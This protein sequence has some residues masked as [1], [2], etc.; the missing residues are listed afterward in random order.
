L[1]FGDLTVKIYRLSIV[2][3]DVGGT[4]A[5]NFITEMNRFI[6]QHIKPT[7]L[8]DQKMY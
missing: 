2:A 1:L 5:P 7:N 8:E 4:T 6:A 3:A